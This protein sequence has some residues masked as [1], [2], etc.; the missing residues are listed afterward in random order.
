MQNNQKK[1][2]PISITLNH[3]EGETPDA[4]AIR[5]IEAATQ[6]LNDYDTVRVLQYSIQKIQDKVNNE[7]LAM[8]LQPPIEDQN[9]PAR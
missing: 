1:P 4:R 2:S 9:G 3:F 8:Q 7:A 6:D 5:F